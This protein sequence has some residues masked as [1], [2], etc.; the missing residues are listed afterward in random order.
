MSKFEG[1]SRTYG[2][3]IEIIK[4]DDNSSSVVTRQSIRAGSTSV[5]FSRIPVET[6]I[7]RIKLVASIADLRAFPTSA[8]KSTPPNTGRSQNINQLTEKS[9]ESQSSSRSSPID[10]V[11]KIISDRSKKRKFDVLDINPKIAIAAVSGRSVVSVPVEFMSENF[12]LKELFGSGLVSAVR[13]VRS[14]SHTAIVRGSSYKTPEEIKTILNDTI[15]T[16][17]LFSLRSKASESV[18]LN[19][20]KVPEL[21]LNFVYNFYS[22][23]ETDK[24]EEQ[25]DPSKDPLL[26]NKS[27]DV[28]RYVELIWGVAKVTEQ[29]TGAEKFVENNR[30]NGNRYI[31]SRPVINEN[32]IKE[33]F[34][35]ISN[36]DVFSNVITVTIGLKNKNRIEAFL[37]VKQNEPNESLNVKKDLE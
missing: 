13:S 1:T 30:T 15:K 16:N 11:V 31:R 25:E 35:S 7:E 29:I 5:N 18:M 21:D 14:V 36:K 22:T 12:G 23:D 9:P 34:N 3:D 24:P 26:K 27:K 2:Q 28:P 32:N 17:M 37:P 20:L 19:T 4:E 8:A 33:G 6:P 10:K